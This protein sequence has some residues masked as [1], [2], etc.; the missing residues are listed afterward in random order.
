MKYL[1]MPSISVLDVAVV[2][3]ISILGGLWIVLAVPWVALSHYLQ[4]K[5]D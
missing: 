1:V 3:S 2:M 4:R 5:Y